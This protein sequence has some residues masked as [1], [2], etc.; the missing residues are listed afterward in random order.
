[1]KGGIAS[2]GRRRISPAAIELCSSIAESSK[3]F[4]VFVLVETLILIAFQQSYKDDIVKRFSVAQDLVDLILDPHEIDQATA[5][6]NRH[7]LRILPYLF[8]NF[9]V[10]HLDEWFRMILHEAGLQ[11]LRT[12]FPGL[13]PKS[14]KQMASV[15]VFDCSWQ[16]ESNEHIVKHSR[17]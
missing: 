12:K 5:I 10:V 8:P 7:R 9:L 17:D 11:R 4:E 14:I 15:I 3:E 2:G 16:I 13:Y 6:G 1:M